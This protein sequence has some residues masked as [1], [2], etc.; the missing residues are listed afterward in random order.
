MRLQPIIYTT[1]PARLIHWYEVVLGHEPSHRSDVWST[2]EVGGATLAIHRVEQVPTASRVA[3][4]LVAEEPLET[5]VGRWST[6][7]EITRAIRDEV[8]GRSV[9]LTD[10]DGNPVQLNEH[11]HPR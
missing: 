10:P 7:I 5:L 1:E 9:L 11:R 4:S 6:R 3:I 2:F 8:F